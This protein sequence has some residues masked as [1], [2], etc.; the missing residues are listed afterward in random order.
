M[1]HILIGVFAL[2]G[3]CAKAQFSPY[4]VPNIDWQNHF[5]QRDLMSGSPNAIDVNSN[6]YLA[7]YTGLSSS[8]AN[9][10]V[11]K[12]DSLGVL[13]YTASYDNGGYDNANAIRVDIAGFA[14]IAGVSDGGATG[15]D[16]VVV[17]VDAAGNIVWSSRF[18]GGAGGGHDEAYDLCV[19][20][21][22]NVCVTGKS[23][24][25]TGND[26]IA[27]K[28]N[29]SSGALIWQHSFNGSANANDEGL[30]IALSANG[31]YVYITGTTTDASNGTDLVTFALDGNSGTYHWVP[32]IT[33]GLANANDKAKAIVRNGSNLAVCGTINNNGNN[34][35]VVIEYNGMTGSIIFQSTYDYIGTNGEAT[36]LA[37]DSAGNIGVVGKVLKGSIY[38][39]HTV[40]YNN[41]GT[42]L[43]FN[44]EQTDLATLTV[45][46]K[47]CND[48]IAHHWYVSGEKQGITR[49]MLV[50][51]IAPSGNTAWRKTVDGQYNDIDAAT[52]IA[53]N[54]VGVVYLGAFSR[55]SASNYDFTAVK[56]NQTPVYF[57]P[58]IV[59]NESPMHGH[60]YYENKGQVIF[61]DTTVAK[62]IL[63]ACPDFYP[64][65]YFTSTR[66]SYKLFSLMDAASSTDTVQRIDIDMLGANQLAD[67]HPYEPTQG[68]L[69]FMEQWL[70]D[71]VTGVQGY[72]RYFIPNVYPYIDLHYY[73]NR[74][75]M[76]LYY[77]LKPFANPASIRWMVSGANG[78]AI[79]GSN[80]V[81]KGFN[82]DVTFDR[83]EVYTINQQGQAVQLQGGGQA[84]WTNNGGVFGI[85]VPTYNPAWPLI[86]EVD[87]GNSFYPPVGP[88]GNQKN[89][90]YYGGAQSEG[91]TA[92]DVDPVSGD[93]VTVF[94]MRSGNYNVHPFPAHP[95]TS[96]SLS[97]NTNTISTMLAVILFD[98]WG[99]RKAANTYGITG[100]PI[101][102]VEVALSGKYITVLANTNYPPQLGN[103][104]LHTSVSGAL[105]A[106]TYTSNH[107]EGIAIQ[108][109]FVP[110]SINSPDGSINQIKW[111]T[112]L[113]G[114]ASDICK[115]PDN[116]NLYITTFQN[117]MSFAPDLMTQPGSYNNSTYNNAS[118]INTYNFKISKFSNLGIRKWST[119]WPAANMSYTRGSVWNNIVP[120]T[121][122]NSDDHVKCKISAD[123]YGFYL[124][125]ETD[126]TG[127]TCFSKY[128][129]PTDNT[130]GGMVDGFFARFNK[131]DSLV[132]STYVGGNDHDAY[133]DIETVSDKEAVMVG[134]SGSKW[135]GVTTLPNPSHYVDTIKNGRKI[136]ISKF[137]SIGNKTYST[138]FGAGGLSPCIAWGVATDHA[139]GNFYVTGRDAGGFHVP[140]AN[141]GNYYAQGWSNGG[142]LESFILGF[143]DGFVVW[144]SFHGGNALEA[145]LAMEVNPHTRRLIMTGITNSR[146]DPLGSE[147]PIHNDPTIGEWHQA[148]LN[149]WTGDNS[150]YDA[151]I[152]V[153]TAEE[154]VGIKEYL[155][156]NVASDSFRLF[157]NPAQ[158]TV[159]LAFKRELMEP[160]S[161]EVY[162]STGQLVLEEHRNHVLSNSVIELLPNKLSNGIY[163]VT[164]KSGGF[165]ETKKLIVSK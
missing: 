147:F 165:T 112:R 128:G 116:Q 158:N 66:I 92:M 126:Q 118:S 5:G 51:Q 12:Y 27:L 133:Y 110:M 136:L 124:A 160:V 62:E 87:Y 96:I 127:M 59:Q 54:G 119:I 145:G 50:Y 33:N 84:N 80:L 2:V 151:F 65:T 17:K 21:S 52:S 122:L 83:P 101:R 86:I 49:D 19:D 43:A 1:K 82:A 98:K 89:A 164:V 75:G 3:L 109:E 38:E 28:L 44:I 57:P 131:R 148:D 64:G 97:P 103:L 157:P 134:H 18:D 102:P 88:N 115:T 142:G 41:T 113:G 22:G 79:N 130:W 61:N 9:L 111:A 8:A 73:S 104:P 40:L 78:A 163:L 47:I 56:I 70:P 155:K 114:F 20:P 139:N 26:I 30:G 81:I 7:G 129:A 85:N 150:A 72:Q 162:S 53:V 93:Y 77:V 95:G 138:F 125:G 6:V 37:T 91:S 68:K 60:L 63:F 144:N 153:F 121:I 45:D 132:Y 140:A 36:G 48:T 24:S 46:P 55:N 105:T 123:N 35:F 156:D 141:S 159:Y 58:D 108:F 11:L 152:A 69:S 161:V 146:P 13:Q 34:D 94:E 23:Q 117:Q 149:N 71:A 16:I 29:G 31:H 15:L 100:W 99:I 120:A 74:N 39:Y 143:S 4:V 137:D 14:Y 107:G 135:T 42:Q 25:A 10:T 67:A 32:V 90:T 76:K 106:S 154:V